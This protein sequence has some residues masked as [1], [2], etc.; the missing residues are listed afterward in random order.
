[1]GN[2]GDIESS[3]EELESLAFLERN[4]ENIKLTSFVVQFI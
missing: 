2:E 4:E 1:M 3:L